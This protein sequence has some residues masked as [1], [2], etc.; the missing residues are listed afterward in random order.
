M[1]PDDGWRITENLRKIFD[2]T[3][4]TVCS[5]SCLRRYDF[6]VRA[7]DNRLNSS[8]HFLSCLRE[9]CWSFRHRFCRRGCS[10]QTHTLRLVLKITSFTKQK[11]TLNIFVIK[12]DCAKNVRENL[13]HHFGNH[14]FYFINV[15]KS[16][17]EGNSGSP[18]Y[19]FV[20]WKATMKYLYSF[21]PAIL[22]K[23]LHMP[24]ICL[25]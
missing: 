14:I 5:S 17:N 10:R 22:A 1:L 4:G 24:I 15:G 21:N 23:F 8:H 16:S 13:F 3:R 12:I 2:T 9:S 20:K 6:V 7:D 19:A 25:S 11:K 18:K